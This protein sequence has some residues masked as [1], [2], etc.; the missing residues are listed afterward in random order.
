MMQKIE[1]RVVTD[2]P[3]A[4]F[5]HA[6]GHSVSLIKEAGNYN[7]Q[8]TGRNLDNAITEYFENGP[9]PIQSYLLS[10]K[11]IRNMITVAK[12]GGSNG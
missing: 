4:V 8:I 9:I 11:A 6:K 2:N 3:L 5:L 7:F 10:F 1:S 12:A